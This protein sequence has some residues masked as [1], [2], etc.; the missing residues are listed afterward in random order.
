MQD[1]DFIIKITII[2]CMNDISTVIPRLICT[3]NVS[4]WRALLLLAKSKRESDKM[5]GIM[6]KIVLEGAIVDVFPLEQ[7]IGKFDA[8]TPANIVTMQWQLDERHN[9][10]IQIFSKISIAR[11]YT[12]IRAIKVS[13]VEKQP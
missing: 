10:I 11:I 2:H 1:A 12:Y 7:T 8:N 13:I 4:E 5:V 6:P 3:Y 9:V